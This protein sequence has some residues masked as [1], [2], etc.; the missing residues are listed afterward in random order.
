MPDFAVERGIPRPVRSAG[1][2]A[3][4]PWREMEVD[5]VLKEPSR[6]ARDD[7]VVYRG[8]SLPRLKCLE[9]LR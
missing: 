4:Y 1:A 7:V 2:I 3:K 5:D 8:V 6:P 9:G